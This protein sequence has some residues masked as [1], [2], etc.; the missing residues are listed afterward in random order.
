MTFG[1]KMSHPS[2]K[3]RIRYRW[4]ILTLLRTSCISTCDFSSD[5]DRIF[6]VYTLYCV[7]AL[8]WYI[9]KKV[10]QYIKC[11]MW[12]ISSSFTVREGEHIIWPFMMEKKYR[13]GHV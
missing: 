10:K 11:S 6:V 2:S 9:Y 8:S 7:Y 12:K 1:S 4:L 3:T 5:R 13:K